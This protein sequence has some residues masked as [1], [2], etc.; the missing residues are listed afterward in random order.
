MSSRVS[1]EYFSLRQPSESRVR[2][3]IKKQ[4]WTDNF[5]DATQILSQ[6]KPSVA[7]ETAM[8]C[9]TIR[10]MIRKQ[11]WKGLEIMETGVFTTRPFASGEVVCDY[12]SRLISRKEGL[13]IH[14]SHEVQAGHL[15]FFTSETGQAMCFDAHD[16]HCE[17]HPNKTALGRLITHSSKRANVRPRLY[18]MEDQE[19]LLFIACRDI[20]E[21]EQLRYDYG[22][23][24]K[25]FA[26]EDLDL[27]WC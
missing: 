17:C 7:V 25:S 3:R 2:S 1:A 8:S 6:W 14:N 18:R 11:R 22:S 12:H 20:K 16:E 26:G 9:R 5:P 27:L 24:K 21:N 15:F 4:G 10:R 19:L 23:N 13:E